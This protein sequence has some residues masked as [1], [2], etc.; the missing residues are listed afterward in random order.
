MPN[1]W[2]TYKLGDIVDQDR[3]ISYGVVQPGTHDPNGIPILNQKQGHPYFP[4][5]Y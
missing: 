3:G 1:N 4:L 5:C 2:K